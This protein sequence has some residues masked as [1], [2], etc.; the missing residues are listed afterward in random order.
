MEVGSS[1]EY[2]YMRKEMRMRRRT[3]APVALMIAIFV[4]MSA[5][6]TMAFADK[7]VAG[8]GQSEINCG[9]PS[10]VANGPVDIAAWLVDKGHE[11]MLVEAINYEGAAKIAGIANQAD[12]VRFNYK[13]H[14]RSK[15][16][17]VGTVIP[18]KLVRVHKGEC[19]QFDYDELDMATG[20]VTH[21]SLP[22][23]KNGKPIPYA[24]QAGDEVDPWITGG[25]MSVGMVMAHNGLPY[26]NALAGAGYLVSTQA[27]PAEAVLAGIG[28]LVYYEVWF[29]N[30]GDWNLLG[31]PAMAGPLLKARGDPTELEAEALHK[32]IA[33]MG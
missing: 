23:D 26:G 14:I 28:Y 10:V 32:A 24:V 19:V 16:I 6:A 3:V 12:K 25:A 11:V 33:N 7:I 18:P 9:R 8:V 2:L 4:L 15:Q 27:T 1:L 31:L 30:I 13:V 21:H 5:F 20:Q 29:P 17:H 22:V